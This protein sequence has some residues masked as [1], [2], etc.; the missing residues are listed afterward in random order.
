MWFLQ[1]HNKAIISLVDN[2]C[3]FYLILA[4]LFLRLIWKQDSS[5]HLLSQILFLLLHKQAKQIQDKSKAEE[6]NNPKFLY[7]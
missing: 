4:R 3:I 1:I 7:Q 5:F 2:E 6:E